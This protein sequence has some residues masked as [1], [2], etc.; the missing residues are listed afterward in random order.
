MVVYS[1]TFDAGVVD[2]DRD[3]RG[4]YVFGTK[5]PFLG[6]GEQA[7][8][9]TDMRVVVPFD[10]LP[11]K[12][13]AIENGSQVT[14]QFRVSSIVDRDAL[15]V[16]VIGL[17]NTTSGLVSAGQYE[18]GGRVLARDVFPNANS[19]ISFDVTDYAQSVAGTGHI[20][21]R[22][23]LNGRSVNG[24]ETRF[25][26]GQADAPLLASKPTLIVR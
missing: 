12:Q 23:Q 4:N 16:D 14:A 7:G 25:T 18:A 11:E 13:A 15:S 8:L 6:T 19:T 9:G 20:V 10:L 22:L 26:V 17:D 2:S 24:A 1:S 3:G 21:L 5:N